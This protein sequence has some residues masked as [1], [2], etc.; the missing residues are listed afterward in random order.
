MWWKT[1]APTKPRKELFYTPESTPERATLYLWREPHY[2]LERAAPYPLERAALYT[3]EPH[4]ILEE[5]CPIPRRQL[6]YTPERA[7]LY[8]RESH[9]IPWREPPISRRELHYNPERAGSGQRASLERPWGRVRIYIVL[10]E[11]HIWEM[12]QIPRTG[13][14]AHGTHKLQYSI[15]QC[16]PVPYM[17][18]GGEQSHSNSQWPTSKSSE[19]IT[20]FSS[21]DRSPNPESVT[22]CGN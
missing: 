4:C 21:P 19:R 17:K 7:T 8:P 3:P 22:H 18:R 16:T 6:H 15:R 12:R 9:T 2:T 1:C 11:F 13:S 5:S 14:P 10:S 20:W